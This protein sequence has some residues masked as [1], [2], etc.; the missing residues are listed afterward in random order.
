MSGY[1]D[2]S[3]FDPN[4]T[5]DSRP[6]R[7]FNIWQWLGVGLVIA[8]ILV[9]LAVIAGRFGLTP[10]TRDMLPVGTSLCILGTVLINSRREA[11]QLAPATRRRRLLIILVAAA[12][13]A[14][15]AALIFYFKGA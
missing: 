2:R 11:V 7:P 12:L 13:C 8:G 10:G 15:V 1:R 5:G 14:L 3:G 9:M 6:A 4:A